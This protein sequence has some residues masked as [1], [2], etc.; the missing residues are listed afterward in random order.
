VAA[1]V[2]VND[3]VDQFE[4]H[5]VRALRI[6][7]AC[8]VDKDGD[9]TERRFG[10]VD[11]GNDA[12]GVSHVNRDAHCLTTISNDGG[13]QFIEPFLTSTGRNDRCTG[14]GQH[15]GEAPAE[16][17]CCTRDE[18]DLTGEVSRVVDSDHDALHTVGGMLVGGMCRYTWTGP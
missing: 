18:G 13:D 11:S 3:L 14:S 1:Q 6:G 7:D 12:V 9:S 8:V 5:L 15:L 4:R 10:L 16:A 2:G 17:R